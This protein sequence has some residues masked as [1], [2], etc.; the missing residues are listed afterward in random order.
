MADLEKAGIELTAKGAATYIKNVTDANRA[1]VTLFETLKGGSGISNVAPALG[2]ISAN[3]GTMYKA[4]AEATKGA[5]ELFEA[6]NK[7]AT[8]FNNVAP[9]ATSAGNATLNTAKHSDTLKSAFASVTGTVG[10]LV[11]GLGNIA[12]S[13]A[14]AVIGSLGSAA[15]IAASKMVDLGKAAGGAVIGGLGTLTSTVAGAIGKVVDLGIQLGITSAKMALGAGKEAVKL[16]SDFSAV[17]TTAGSTTGLTGQALDDFKEKATQVGL[18][19]GAKL[20]VSASEAAGAILELSKAGFTA[21]AA[22]GAASGT[23]LLSTATNLK[24]DKSAAL[25][26]STINQFGL[27]LGTTEEATTSANRVVDLLAK[28]ANASAVD[29]TDLGETF[30]YVGPLAKTAGFSLEDVAKATGVLGNAG[31]KGSSAGTGLKMVLSQLASPSDKAAAAFKTLGY[32]VTD[33]NGKIRPLQDQLVDLRSRFKDLSQADKIDLA[34]QIAGQDHFTKFL[35]LIDASPESFNQMSDAID[36][37]SG[38]AKNLSDAFNSTLAGSTENMKGSIETLQ[39]KFGRAL[40][41]AVI[42]ANNAIANLA[43]NLGPLA[44]KFG[45]MVTGGI[46]LA[47]KS[48][49]NLKAGLS[50]Q[51][52]T[53]SGFSS[54]LTK[55]TKNVNL[56]GLALQPLV[57]AVKHLF[58]VFQAGKSIKTSSDD[59]SGFGK[60]AGDLHPIIDGIARAAAALAP[61]LIS[62]GEGAMKLWNQ[63]GPLVKTA[64]DLYTQFSPLSIAFSTLEGFM[65]G[66]LPGAIDALTG[67][68][69][70]LGTLIGGVLNTIGTELVKHGPEILATLGTIATNII[71]WIGQQ[72]PLIVNQLAVWGKAF[73]DWVA[74]QIPGMLATLGNLVVAGLG[75]IGEQIPKIVEGLAKWGASFIAWVEPQIPG[76]LASLGKLITD[77]LGWIGEQIPKIV[78]QLGEWGKSFIDWVQPQ[79]GPMLQE[80]GKFLGQITGWIVGHI[81]DIIGKLTE[82]GIAFIGWVATDVIPKLPGVLAD[83]LK[84]IIA[85]IGSA[86]PEITSG[87]GRWVDGIITKATDLV[88]SLPETMNKAFNAAIKAIGDFIK[89]ASSAIAKLPGELLKGI[90]DLGSLLVNAGAQLIQGFIRGFQSIHIPFPH[91]SA[92]FHDENFGPVTIPV[93]YVNVNW[94]KKGGIFSSPSVV[95]VGEAG[96]EAALPISDLVPLMAA[97][98]DKS[99]VAKSDAVASPAQMYNSQQS[100]VA[101]D[102]RQ[103][104]LNV[105]TPTPLNNVVAGFELMQVLWGNS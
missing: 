30:K 20:P 82:W 102:Q 79:I 32:N 12:G 21:D 44:D 72:L 25:V 101:T 60:K 98:L 39:I 29:V 56:L 59:I 18:E 81:P 48:F 77:G 96:Q 8:A 5:K 7:Q 94:Y 53:T 38:T 33:A 55:I 61:L 104:N 78:A 27:A 37:A 75:W 19:L 64:I 73:I 15:G 51:V 17:I 86:L 11:S 9:A 87:I 88:T 66:G 28:T 85:F 100:Y 50:G 69:G 58:N 41:P 23:A 65:K 40:A 91:F 80:L 34:K 4:Q 95:G 62:I 71:T 70:N 84:G 52:T 2:Q 103:Y 24:M 105:N 93:P 74:P 76:M 67:K 45:G 6:T 36:N 47:T 89:D 31:I 10:G 13:T 35:A 26:S 90:G 83:I 63:F 57:L 22:L 97:A 49:T 14:H 3:L 1:T 42:L 54:T 68:L 99:I 46:D 43:N 16:Y 92:G